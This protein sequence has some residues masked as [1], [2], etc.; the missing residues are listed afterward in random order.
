MMLFKITAAP[1]FLGSHLSSPVSGDVLLFSFSSWHFFFLFLFPF[2]FFGLFLVF[3]C[4]FRATPAMLE[5]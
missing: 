3:F 2:F 1:L 4:L 5:P